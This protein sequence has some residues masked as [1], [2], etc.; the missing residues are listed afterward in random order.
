VPRNLRREAEVRGV[1]PE[2]LV[3]APRMKFEDHL[4]RH[5]LA[6]L[7]LDTLP[8]N[9]HTTANDALWA[10]LPLLTCKG[11]TFPG[12]VAA[13]LLNAIGLNELITNSLEEYEALAV[14]L[15]M[16]PKRLAEIRS[17]LAENRDTYPLFDTDRFRRHVEAAYTR[18]WER[19][20]R[21]EPPASFAVAPIGN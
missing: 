19:Y 4:A 3:F 9:A 14:E 18:M 7:F 6:D 13:S 12:R 20:Q 17:K 16:N 15:A 8:Y 10:G 5:R 1:A 2:R 21:G 11:T